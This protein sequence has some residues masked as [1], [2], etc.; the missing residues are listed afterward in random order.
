M[1]AQEK[2][3]TVAD[4]DALPDDDKRYELDRG[5]LIVMPPPKPEHGLVVSRMD[6]FIGNHVDANHLGRVLAESG[7]QLS[8][9]PDTVRAPDI[10]FT[11]NA[12]L[13]PLTGE[14]LQ[15]APDLAVEV[16]SPGNT[17]DDMNQKIEQYFAAGVRLVWVL[18]PKTRT[19]YVYTSAR[20]VTILGLEDTLEGGDVLPGFAVSVR[21]IFAVL[22]TSEAGDQKI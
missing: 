7:Y 15:V 18:Y 19:I 3:Y 14:Y 22:D 9:H 11:S 12:R 16:A 21:E 4:L 1:V 6:R 2:L 5:R 13:Q 10:S 8:S 17:V 20:K